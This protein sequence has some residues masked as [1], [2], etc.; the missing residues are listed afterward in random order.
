MGAF[1]GRGRARP[2]PDLASDPLDSGGSTWEAIMS[3]ARLEQRFLAENRNKGKRSNRSEAPPYSE[4][5]TLTCF[6]AQL[7]ASYL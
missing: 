7:E 4:L 2:S 5:L 1:A 3:A 6:L